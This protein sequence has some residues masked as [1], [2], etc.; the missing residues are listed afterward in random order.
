VAYTFGPINSRRFGLSLGV[1]L[2]PNKKQCNFDCLYCELEPAKAIDAQDEIAS[3]DAIVAELQ[4]VLTD[5]LDLITIT[6]NGEPTLYPHLDELI[7][8]ITAIKGS[9]KTLILTNGST[10]SSEQTF[11][12]LLKLDSVKISLDAISYEVFKKIDRPTKSFDLAS[13]IDAMRRFS[14]VYKGDLF[15]EILLVKSIND[16]KSELAK[17]NET[18]LSFSNLTRVDLGTIDRPPAY[19]VTPLTYEE[20]FEASL[21]FSSKLPIHIASRGVGSKKADRE[22]SKEEL[23]HTLE[24]RSLSLDD[25]QM[26]LDDASK[27]RF[28][29]LLEAKLITTKNVAGVEFYT[30]A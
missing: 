4:S 19:R 30:K 3:V 28:Y 29:D 1:D 21:S 5:D 24:M 23:L 13:S 26:L 25:I 9:A 17:L 6:A 18:L 16:Q 7:D 8:A 14:E 22:F 2:S 15:I 27:K 12:S 20:L 11:A 10:L